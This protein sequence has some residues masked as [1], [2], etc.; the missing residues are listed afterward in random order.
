MCYKHLKN[1][2]YKT[3]L[4][5]LQNLKIV[6]YSQRVGKTLFIHVFLNDLYNWGQCVKAEL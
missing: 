3:F 4:K 6:E 2:F 5:G 1:T